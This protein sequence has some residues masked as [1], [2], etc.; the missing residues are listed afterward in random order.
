MDD[1]IAAPGPNQYLLI[2]PVVSRADPT[3]QCYGQIDYQGNS[4]VLARIGI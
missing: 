3:H 1:E 2:L 4:R